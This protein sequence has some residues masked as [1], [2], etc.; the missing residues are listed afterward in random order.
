MTAMGRIPP[1]RS[2]R[3]GRKADIPDSRRWLFPQEALGTLPRR[4]LRFRVFPSKSF[5]PSGSEQETE[6][7]FGRSLKVGC[8]DRDGCGRGRLERI[9]D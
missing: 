9:I 7:A 3:L 1:G 8:W 6:K 5:Y 4:E 2:R